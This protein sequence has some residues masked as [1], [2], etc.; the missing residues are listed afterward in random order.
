MHSWL[1]AQKRDV[2]HVF[3]MLRAKSNDADGQK[4]NF[5]ICSIIFPV[6]VQT[7]E[8]SINVES[9]KQFYAE[10]IFHERHMNSC[11]IGCE[12]CAVSASTTK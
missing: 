2:S 12:G 11:P 9:K 10:H 4:A 6:N 1:T 7:A 3:A 8:R 5:V